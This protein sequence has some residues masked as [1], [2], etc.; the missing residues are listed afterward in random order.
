MPLLS[1]NVLQLIALAALSKLLGRAR[2]D[3]NAAVHQYL[4]GS[5]LGQPIECSIM[6]CSNLALCA[7]I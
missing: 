2:L 5:G 3:A 1:F 6:S 7:H 4:L